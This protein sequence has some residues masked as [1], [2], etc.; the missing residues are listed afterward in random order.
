MKVP[1]HPEHIKTQTVNIDGT[2]QPILLIQILAGKKSDPSELKLNWTFI[3]F[4]PTELQIHLEFENIALVS[5]HRSD[6]DQILVTVLGNN[7]FESEL[8]G[9]ISASY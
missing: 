4:T 1:A 6:P 7:Y 2:E 8:G 9:Y 3:S 5:R